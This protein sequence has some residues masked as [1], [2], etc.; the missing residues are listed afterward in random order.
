MSS[1]PRLVVTRQEPSAE[2]PDHR[3]FHRV[4]QSVWFALFGRYRT[5]STTPSPGQRPYDTQ[6]KRRIP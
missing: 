4:D 3:V 2:D 5:A 1:P 6:L